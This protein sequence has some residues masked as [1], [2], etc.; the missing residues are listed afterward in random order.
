MAAGTPVVAA[1][2]GALPETCG[3]AAVLVEPDGEA[4]AA[5]LAAL[6]G[7]DA[8]ARAAARGRPRAGGAAS[9]GTRTARAVD[10]LLS[11]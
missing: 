4:F 9:R 8:R 7:D 1:A 5:A 3:G 2:A 10:A 11:A 6:L